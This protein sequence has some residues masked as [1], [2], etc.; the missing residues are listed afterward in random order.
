MLSD[1]VASFRREHGRTSFQGA[2]V[3]DVSLPGGSARARSQGVN[4]VIQ[5]A[6]TILCARLKKRVW[7]EEE[8]LDDGDGSADKS[9][10][11]PGVDGEPV[12][13]VGMTTQTSKA[14][15]SAST[16]VNLGENDVHLRQTRWL[17]TFKAEV[18]FLRGQFN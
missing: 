13:Q 10:L 12:I 1:G 3:H 2:E 4:D 9:D 14:M 15:P 8:R 16:V 7:I 11:I 17:G 5:I 6:T 18:S